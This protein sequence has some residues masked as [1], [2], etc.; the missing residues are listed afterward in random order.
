M[1]SRTQVS[2]QKP[3]TQKKSE[4]KAKDR[5]SRGQGEECSRP[6]S[7]TKDTSKSA[8]QKKGLQ[9][10]FFRRSPKKQEKVFTKIF[11]AISRKKRLP[12]IF[13]GAPQNFNIQK[14]VLS[15]SRRQANFRELEA[16]RPRTSKCIL[17]DSTSG[18][19]VIFPHYYH[20]YLNKF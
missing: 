8:L 6:R 1:E 16:L 2:R 4:A 14:M 18:N 5:S 12:K 11:Q 7:R 19:G 3:T 9:T 17:E 15:S 20:V 10:F 13:S